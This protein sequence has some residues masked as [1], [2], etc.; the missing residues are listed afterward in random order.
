[1]IKLM[2][3]T[4]LT[5]SLFLVISFPTNAQVAFSPLVED[6]ISET[7]ET[8]ITELEEPLTGNV[9]AII[10]GEE[11]TIQTRNAYQEG[12][13]MAA[14]WIFERLEEYGYEP[15]YHEFEDDGQNVI[16][17]KTGT[18]YPDQQYIICGHY[19]DM[20]S[21][22][23]AP[24]ADDNASG[25]VGTLEAAR[26]LA[27]YDT[28]YTI[29]FALWDEEELGLV[30]SE[31]YAEEAAA[32]GDDIK[33]VINLDMIAWESQ[34]DFK[35]SIS[36]N[37]LSNELT[38]D[39]VDILNMYTPEI[40][41]NYISSTASDHASFWNEGYPALLLIE[42][43]DD[44]NNY[45]H[46]VDDDMDILNM[47]YFEK[48]TRGAL[49]GI[50]TFAMDYFVNLQHEPIT[51]GP[52]TGGR[53][54]VL[55]TDSSNSYASGEDA[56]RLY[57]KV[58]DGD[59]QHL[60]PIETNEDTLTFLIPGQSLGSEVEYYFA[61]QGEDDDFVATLPSGGRGI[62]P[63]GTEA[64]DETFSYL[65]DE[66]YFANQCSNTLPKPIED[67]E[68]TYDTIE[69]NQSGTVLDVDVK[70]HLNHTYDGDLT[71]VM[72]GPAEDPVTLSAVNGGSGD[73]YLNTIF[74]D[75]AEQSIENGSAPFTG[76]YQPEE[77]LSV[78]DGLTMA[79][80]WILQVE[81]N[82]YSDEGT[83]NE[84]CVIIQYEPGIQTAVESNKTTQKQIQLYPVPT[85]DRLNISFHMEES[86]RAV[87]EIKDMKGRTVKTLANKT[88][89]K[90]HYQMYTT[91]RDLPAGQYLINLQ[92]GNE[93]ITKKF[94]VS[95]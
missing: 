14:Q 45:Y 37:S 25:T 74:D 54:A 59:Y 27:E 80:D 20:P 87:L 83:L 92:T 94:V 49:A 15:Y 51:S 12:N 18:E 56:P 73:D 76:H 29:I 42:D 89:N 65:V 68:T 82:G 69:I 88:F 21:G 52:E 60:N 36:T 71:L 10:D 26:I 81:D 19:D 55:V 13:Q 40:E 93:Q 6:L 78:H 35:C 90:G 77:P 46:T 9:P 50:T 79:G 75:E 3:T 48:L 22:P 30:G 23:V 95:H 5:L 16:A 31:Y 58:N 47:E 41:P 70:V 1:M 72:E 43:M 85:K 32:N 2:K 17:E 24:G 84:W 28:K 91:V 61:V 62:N 11:Y 53:E 33:G 34:G 39:F 4:I 57:Y 67:N 8:T 86:S 38:S 63:P 44:F 64:P 66:I 7:T